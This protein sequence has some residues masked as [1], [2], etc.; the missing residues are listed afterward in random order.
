[1]NVSIRIWS[2]RVVTDFVFST[3]GD[4]SNRAVELNILVF[5]HGMESL[6]LSIGKFLYRAKR[7]DRTLQY[8]P[9]RCGGKTRRN[10]CEKCLLKNCYRQP[11][12]AERPT[13]RR[14]LFLRSS[15][16]DR[17]NSSGAL[18]SPRRNPTPFGRMK[19]APCLRA[20]H[21]T[22]G[23]SEEDKCAKKRGRTLFPRLFCC[24][25]LRRDEWNVL[26]RASGKIT[27]GR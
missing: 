12:G 16:K 15:P 27:F 6:H 3:R 11:F 23:I 9:W 5:T 22:D 8:R 21:L 26:L 13:Q 4:Q 20:A 18:K 1:M 17:R 19:G 2:Y 10:R 24:S 25:F 14:P 7:G